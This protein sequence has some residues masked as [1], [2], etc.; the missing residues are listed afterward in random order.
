MVSGSSCQSVLADIHHFPLRD[1]LKR[2]DPYPLPFPRKQGKGA[3][4]DSSE[5]PPRQRGGI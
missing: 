1:C 3:M 5:V 4:H 2:I